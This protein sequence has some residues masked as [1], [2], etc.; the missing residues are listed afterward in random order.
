MPIPSPPTTRF[1]LLE[2]DHVTIR[3]DVDTH[4][5]DGA[6]V[7]PVRTMDPAVALREFLAILAS[8]RDAW[9]TRVTRDSP[10]V[11][12]DGSGTHLAILASAIHD[13]SR[14]R[15]NFLSRYPRHVL[16]GDPPA[17]NDDA[18][19]LPVAPRRLPDR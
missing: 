10:F 4:D 14:R 3:F 7:H 17:S 18:R 1:V 13:A 8:D 12:R 19:F 15:A 6:V 11:A 2:P 16:D 9:I 5:E